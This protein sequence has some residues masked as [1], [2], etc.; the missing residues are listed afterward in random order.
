VTN[1]R[2]CTVNGTVSVI[3]TATNTVTTTVSV[4]LCPQK[5]AINPSGTFVYVPNAFSDT[6]S[7]INTAT[8]TVTATIPT[9][10]TPTTVAFP[11]RTPIVSLIAQVQALIAEGVLTQK[12]GDTLIKKLEGI[13]TKH[14]NDQTSAVCGQLG[15]FIN[16]VNALINNGSLTT[17][18]GQALIEAANAIKPTLGC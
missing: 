1:A 17:S 4:G 7:V 5:L 6:I 15:A 18:Q 11:T 9:G 14:N 2:E 12:Q 8:N 16:Q 10:H 3:N 13:Q